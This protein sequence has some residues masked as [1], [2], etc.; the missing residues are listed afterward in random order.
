MMLSPETFS[1]S[2][3]PRI[4]KFDFSNQD[5]PLREKQQKVENDRSVLTFKGHFVQNMHIKCYFSPVE[6]TG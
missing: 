1:K 4:T 3:L 2:A 6:T 5:Y